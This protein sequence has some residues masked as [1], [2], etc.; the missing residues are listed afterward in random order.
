MFRNTPACPGCTG[1]G[2]RLRQAEQSIIQAPPA[3]IEQEWQRFQTADAPGLSKQVSG[4]EQKL[5]GRGLS[6][7]GN[8][9]LFSLVRERLRNLG[10]CLIYVFSSRHWAAGCSEPSRWCCSW[11]QCPARLAG[12]NLTQAR[13]T[14]GPAAPTAHRSRSV[15]PGLSTANQPLPGA[16]R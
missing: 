5:L 9:A 8:Q 11:G 6:E 1:P 10:L 15:Q 7:Q 4:A 3:L 14:E 13:S 2:K 12:E 16:L